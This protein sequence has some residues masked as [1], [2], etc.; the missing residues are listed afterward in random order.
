MDPSED[1]KET[2][3]RTIKKT[4]QL[5]L[6]LSLSPHLILYTGR[7][8]EGVGGGEKYKSVL[9]YFSDGI[10][11]FNT[12]GSVGRSVPMLPPTHHTIEENILFYFN[13]IR[14]KKHRATRSSWES[15]KLRQQQQQKQHVQS[16]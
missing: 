9:L 1:V 12:S 16:G 11:S 13:S 8:K 14:I 5:Y 10:R 6:S 4:I 15:G 7:G 2:L 3:E